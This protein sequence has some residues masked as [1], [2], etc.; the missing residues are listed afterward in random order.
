M[1][2]KDDYQEH[3]LGYLSEIQ[4]GIDQ[5]AR[6]RLQQ[7]ELQVLYTD[8]MITSEQLWQL[9]EARDDEWEAC[10]YSLEAS[11]ERL[12]RELNHMP[13]VG[14]SRISAGLALFEIVEVEAEFWAIADLMT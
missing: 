12:L 6:S 7:Y 13:R 1:W 2:P 14:A 5:F 9:I 4:T 10:R 11:C 3:M 8:L